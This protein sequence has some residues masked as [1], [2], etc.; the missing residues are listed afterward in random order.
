ML[1]YS[2]ADILAVEQVFP[3][4]KLYLCDIHREHSWERWIKN[5]QNRVSPEDQDTL[6]ELLHSCAWALPPDL[7]ES[8]PLDINYHK[9]VK[10]L[11]ESEIW[12]KLQFWLSTTWLSI[13]EVCTQKGHPST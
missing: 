8:L 11:K 6:L 9:T 10:N 13:P 12:N 3:T 1:N 7:S 2:E 4:A 5:Q